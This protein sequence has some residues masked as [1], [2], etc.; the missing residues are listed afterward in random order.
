VQ[1]GP[2]TFPPVVGSAESPTLDLSAD[3][4]NLPANRIIYCRVGARNSGDVLKP[5][6]RGKPNPGDY[7]YSR[8]NL[9]FPKAAE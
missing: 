6:A 4:P 8:L 1:K 9:T 2:F 7:V 5:E 3:F